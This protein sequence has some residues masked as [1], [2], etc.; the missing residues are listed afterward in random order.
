MRPLSYEI[1]RVPAG[2]TK[3]E[4]PFV[5]GVL[6]DFTGQPLEPLPRL[7]ERKFIEATSD[8]IDS[9]LKGM[10]AHLHF[11]VENRMSSDPGALQ[12]AIDLR[13]YSLDD[14]EPINIA[15]QIEPLRTLLDLKSTMRD[16]ASELTRNPQ[17]DAVFQRCL[18][19][20]DRSR[21]IQSDLAALGQ[22]EPRSFWEKARDVPPGNLPSSISQVLLD[23]GW[24]A[25]QWVEWTGRTVENLPRILTLFSSQ[26]QPYSRD[27]GATIQSAVNE[28]DRVIA[29]QLDAVLHHPNLQRLDATW[30][31]V[32]YLVDQ[33]R[34]LAG[35]K[36]RLL[37]V[38][39]KELLR[40]LQ[41]APEFDQSSLYRLG[42]EEFGSLGGEPFSL[43]IG[44]GEISAHPED[45]ELLEKISQTAASVHC[46][47]LGA[48]APSVMNVASFA[49]LEIP[50]SLRHTF[51]TTDYAKWN[52]FRS[53]E[54]SRYIGLVL[55]RILLRQ[56]HEDESADWPPCD[57]SYNETI[58][59]TED[60]L[61]GN[62]AFALAAN[63][64]R[65]FSSTGLAQV[66]IGEES[67][68]LITGLPR[69]ENLS[70]G[71]V[72]TC[73]TDQR[74]AE[75][76]ELGFIAVC[77]RKNSGEAVI[78][79]LPSCHRPRLVRGQDA[80]NM[81]AR[82]S[83]QLEN[84]LAV[85]RFAH[86]LKCIVRDKVGTFSKRRDWEAY[87]NQW[88]SQYVGPQDEL[89]EGEFPLSSASIEV[90]GRNWSDPA[91]WS[92]P[93]FRSIVVATL[94]PRF[95][96]RAAQAVLRVAISLPQMG[97]VKS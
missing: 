1:D 64:A 76:S 83:G 32:Q 44:A 50:R 70:A 27:S 28:L 26:S 41:R 34:E 40:D 54:D 96:N 90:T 14:F 17:L 56:P 19:E 57:L 24:P 21:I 81:Q 79:D 33:C 97:E 7:R 86:Y 69:F 4:L 47:Y 46:V 84:V 43:W 71:P 37:N 74:H 12:L 94:S 6:A 35:V 92:F 61:W 48:P 16:L 49:D 10:Q 89:A 3:R 11:A 29:A 59:S 91:G 68:G 77:Q 5:I 38:T 66:I 45:V 42:Y 95:R 8:N 22:E 52:S 67:G 87:L 39:R 15:R 80:L 62:A 31:G 60:L 23:A 53:S 88:I 25:S 30:R 63:L 55:P 9:V 18:T 2:T 20:R 65:G 85:N 78:F 75:L 72:E 82:L 93:G 58:Q 13:F 73:I 36:V 51:Q